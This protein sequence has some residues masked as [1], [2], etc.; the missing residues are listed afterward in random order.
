MEKLGCGM[1]QLPASER[2]ETVNKS[3]TP[4]FGELVFTLPLELKKNGKRTSRVGPLG[5]MNDG[6][7]LKVP[8]TTPLAI[9]SA[10]RFGPIFGYTLA[11]GPVPPTVGCE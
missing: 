8:F 4:P 2:P 10:S 3:S 11:L 6:M 5:V 1:L 7:A 9:T